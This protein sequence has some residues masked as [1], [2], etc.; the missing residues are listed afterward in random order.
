[1]CM[2]SGGQGVFASPISIPADS[3]T[4][5]RQ[6]Q[7]VSLPITAALLPA[8]SGDSPLVSPAED[9]PQAFGSPSAL[10]SDAPAALD[11]R[12]S[13]AAHALPD[14]AT[15]GAA[16][17]ALWSRHRDDSSTDVPD[18]VDPQN[19][20]AESAA[21]Q[22]A[23]ELSQQLPALTLQAETDAL[24][25]EAAHQNTDDGAAAS[26]QA[27]TADL[28]DQA[29]AG[30]QSHGQMSGSPDQPSSSQHA[31]ISPEHATPARLIS[32][33]PEQAMPSR[34]YNDVP[35]QATSDMPSVSELRQ[36]EPWLTPKTAGTMGYGSWWTPPIPKGLTPAWMKAKTPSWMKKMRQLEKV[37]QVCIMQVDLNLVLIRLI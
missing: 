11:P 2:Q 14:Q 23:V 6:A 34:M 3:A 25:Q 19:A 9:P 22:P 5:S 28:H 33:W 27:Q 15:T 26:A 8:E 37:N 1:M 21:A 4:G 32:S 36:P 16:A 7:E 29:T 24:Q 31:H 30:N 10:W 18:Q 35:E 20:V 13:Q 12:E 17:T